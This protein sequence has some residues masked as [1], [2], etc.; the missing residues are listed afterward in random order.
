MNPI[1]RHWLFTILLLLCAAVCS[2][3]SGYFIPSAKFSSSMTN[4]IVQDRYGYV[5]IATENGLNRFDGYKFTSYF[6]STDDSTAL[7]SNIVVKLF[8]DSQGRLWVGTR[9]GLM[10]YNYADDNFRAI[11]MPDEIRP[12]VI[13]ALETKSG[14][15]LFG[16]SGRGLFRLND[17]IVEKVPDGYTSPGG[18]WYF[19]QMI[20]D[21]LGRFWKCGY[22]EELTVK[23]KDG[24]KQ[25]FIRQ[26]IVVKLIEACGQIIIIGVHGIYSVRDGKLSKIY[27][28]STFGKEIFACCA[29]ETRDGEIYI[30]T[31][32]DG[33]FALD[34]DSLTLTHVDCR[35]REL[36]INTAK[37]RCLGEDHYG[38]LWIGCEG[39]GLVVMPKNRPQFSFWT[40]SGLGGNDC[41]PVTSICNGD[42]GMVWC[43]VQG[44]GVFGFDSSGHIAARPDAPPSAEYIYRDSKKRYWLG[45]GSSLYM[46]NPLTGTSYLK[47]VFDCDRVNCIAEDNDGRLYVSLFSRGFSIFNPENGATKYYNS[48]DNSVAEGNLCNNWIFAMTTDNNGNI[49]MATSAGVSCFDPEKNSFASCGFDRLCDAKL[50]YTLAKGPDGTIFMGTDQGVWT[51]TAGDTVERA[52]DEGR[53]S[54]DGK[55]INYI[56]VEKDGS[57]WCSTPLGIWQYDAPEKKYIG[58]IGGNGLADKEYMPSVGYCSDSLI[59]FGGNEGLAVFNP[60]EVVGTH[61][62]MPDL[63]LSDFLVAGRPANRLT[64][65]DGRQVTDRAVPESNEFEVSYLDNNVALEFSLLDFNSPDNVVFEYRIN[66]DNW[67]KNP[68]GNNSINLAHLQS[69]RYKIEVRALSEGSVSEPYTV[70]LRVRPPWYKSGAAQAVYWVLLL[71]IGLLTYRILRKV[72]QRRMYEEKVKFLIN[73]TH[74]IRSP[75]TL[76]IDPLAQLK[77][78]VTD[79]KEIS[80][81]N[82]IDKN[83]KRLLLLVNQILDRRR[84]DKKQLQLRCRETDLPAFCDGIC[85]AYRFAAQ[86]RGITF[87]FESDDSPVMA[88]IDRINF[89][90]VV[91]N[92]ISNAFKYTP[93]NGEIIVKVFAKDHHACVEVTDSGRGIPK[94]DLKKIFNRFYQGRNSEAYGVEGSG[95]GLDL[96]LGIV[97]MHGG[98]I[99]AENRSDGSTGAR[100][101]I[102]IPEGN[103]HLK[104]SQ[105][106]DGDEDGTPASSKQGTGPVKILIADDDSDLASYI[107]GDLGTKYRFEYCGDGR[108][109]LQKLLVGDFDLVI[110]DVVMPR[111][112]G[113][114]LLKNIKDNPNISQLP[115]ILLSAKSEAEDKLK[116]LKYGADAYLAKPFSLEELSV[117]IDN[118]IDNFRRLKGKFSGIA[119]RRIEDIE[120]KGNDDI[121]MDRIM[122]AVNAHMS[123]PDFNVDSLTTEV[124]ISRVQLHRKMKEITGIP[125]GKFLRNIRMEQAAKLLREGAINITQVADSIGYSDAGYFSNVFKKHFGISPSEY[126]EKYKG[127]KQV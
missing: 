54:F 41:P 57:L 60:S 91:S 71:L 21:S 27:D 15:L 48:N 104:P 65:S 61:K 31:R 112:D 127:D 79:E 96:S 3:Q 35:V 28:F 87:T 59:I 46:Y 39:K 124:G 1:I 47:A 20:E 88:W 92:I 38:N 10:L 22:G 12:R 17:S 6:C 58:H 14:E 106:V 37:I 67:L 111:M 109:A 19:N 29:C 56:A 100:F 89:D 110:S 97:Q 5:W 63:K 43:T 62:K 80:Y 40:L 73:A 34:W 74:D 121:L 101:T 86:K 85:N 16:T 7:N 114:T 90:K 9:R 11:P 83:A 99:I 68:V 51:Y 2:A 105:I 103:A 55:I 30:G 107:M 69:G 115:V 98:T 24:I 18:N 125:A 4:D 118:L 23:D 32:G 33:L 117:R 81:L 116:G 82:V 102:S 8:C 70:M 13:S 49:W 119:E 45:A 84:I 93:D 94:D 76:I 36:N 95:I 108:S 77:N 78:I 66:D 122:E 126:M 72:A 53:G 120:V 26:D 25:F 113:I 123:D 52:F 50:C 75:L 64:L 44:G 42:G